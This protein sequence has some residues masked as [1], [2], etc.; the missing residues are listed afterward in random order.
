MAMGRWLELLIL[1]TWTASLALPV[2]TT[3]RTG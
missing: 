2:F 3:C 1:L